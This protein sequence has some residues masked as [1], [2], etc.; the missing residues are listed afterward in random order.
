VNIDCINFSS[1]IPNPLHT[2]LSPPG[3]GSRLYLPH[4]K[5]ETACGMQFPCPIP[6][7]P[8]LSSSFLAQVGDDNLSPGH[9]SIVKRRKKYNYTN[10]DPPVQ[11]KK[12][13]CGPS[14][15]SNLFRHVFL[16]CSTWNLLSLQMAFDSQ[17]HFSY[18]SFSNAK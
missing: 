17:N 8:V 16:P 1:V 9:T 13:S 15:I 5:E 4:S 10:R 18:P 12:V 2:V 11:S 3:S 14:S 6:I 7:H